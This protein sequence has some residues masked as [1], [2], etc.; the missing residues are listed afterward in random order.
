M[1]AEIH[2]L[3]QFLLQ[4]ALHQL[5]SSKVEEVAE[6]KGARLLLVPE[7]V[8]TA[9]LDVVSGASWNQQGPLHHLGVETGVVSPRMR[10]PAQ[11]T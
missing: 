10:V 9:D 7:E 4:P 11:V 6:G 5:K 2:V 8:A 1:T 3:L